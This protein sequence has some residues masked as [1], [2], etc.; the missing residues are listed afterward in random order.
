MIMGLSGNTDWWDPRLVHDTLKRHKTVIFDNRGAGRTD[1]PKVAYT[2]KMFADDTV[3]LMSA[4]KIERAHILGI[5]MGGMIAQEFAL[6]HPDRVE[7]LVLCSATCGTSHSVQ[8]YPQALDVLMRPREGMTHEEV[9]KTWIP[10]LFTEDFVKTNA[11]Y[12]SAATQQALRAPITADAYQRQIGA[13]LNFD[14]Y[15]RLPKIKAATL[16]MQGKKD[17]IVP[18]QNARII[19]DRIP[20]AR[21][22]YFE[23]SGHALFSQEPENVNKALLEFIE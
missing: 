8:P 11:S 14:T 10:L 15:E 7:K 17:I 3:G 18:P 1:K 13:I 22:V 21:L 19:A 9:V 2:I 6:N 20:G 16:V 5:S 12:L 23:N 4:L